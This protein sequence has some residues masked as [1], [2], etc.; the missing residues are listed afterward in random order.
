[1]D[2]GNVFSGYNYIIIE[3][4]PKKAKYGD[5][6]LNSVVREVFAR[7]G[8]KKLYDH[9]ARGITL[10]QKGKNIVIEAPTASGKSE[11]YISRMIEK[12]LEGKNSIIVYPTK[13]LARDQLKRFEHFKL[14]GIRVSVYDGDT[15]Q[16]ERERIRANPPHILMT[17]MDML[18]HILINNRLFSEFLKHLELFVLDE[19]HIY[20]GI[21][22]AHSA[23]IIERLKRV[24]KKKFSG[25]MQFVATSATIA[26]PKEF[27]ETIFGEKFELVKGESAPAGRRIH[28]I[29]APENESY[30][31]A[32][33]KIA[34]KLGMKGLIFAN[35]HGVV[36]RMGIMAKEMG[37][38]LAVYRSGLTDKERRKI[39]AEFKEGMYDWLATTSALELGIDIGGVD[40]V[41]LAGYPGTITRVK[42]RIGRAG[43]KG[44][45]AYGIFVARESPLDYYFVDRPKE[46]VRGKVESCYANPQNEIIRKFHI[47]AKAKDMLLE[48]NEEDEDRIRELIKEGLMKEWGNFY[49]L[50]REGGRVVR[51]LSIRGIGENVK[52]YDENNECIGNRETYMAISELFPGAIYLHGGRAY[53]GKELNLEEGVA[54][55]ERYFGELNEYTKALREKEAEV[56]EQ[57]AQRE[58][59]GL[60]VGYGKVH[61]VDSV[62]GFV[63]RDIYSGHR[64]SEHIFEKPY[65]F[66]FDSYAMWIDLDEL[67]YQIEDFGN[68]LHAFEHMSI[69]ITPAITGS[70]A[71][72]LGGISYPSGRM[73]IYEGVPYGTGLTKV[74]F[75]RFEEVAEM[76]YERLKNCRCENGCPKCILDPNCGNDNRFLSKQAGIEIGEG[77]LRRIKKRR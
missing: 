25:K 44:Q 3:E 58:I 17:N 75:E 41:I 12:A 54:K 4:E 66:E 55:V 64:I 50:T 63:V 43:R 36:E 40:A 74:V 71:K 39:E 16:H 61:I 21:F 20:S 65:T 34:K 73:Y 32:A 59:G 60:N 47:L 15:S 13:A 24:V 8:I 53:I 68:G 30:T 22:G 38:N 70:D 2:L 46:Y 77:I 14:Y 5:A 56:Y 35:S 48:K 69:N 28:A 6:K 57:L 29:V 1:M 37:I 11:V 31:T 42:Q 76:A 51:M 10:L 9:Q 72:E 18:H 26:N 23:N 27:A 67:V 19:L 52:I 62:F 33:L 7:M 49:S 45:D